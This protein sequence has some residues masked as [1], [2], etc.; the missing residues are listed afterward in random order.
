MDKD[1]RDDKAPKNDTMAKRKAKSGDLI[2]SGDMML[3]RNLMK[4][5]A[6]GAR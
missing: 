5:K 1:K 2:H 6:T 4:R 3:Q